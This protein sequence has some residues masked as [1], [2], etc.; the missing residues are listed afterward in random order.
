MH[1]VLLDGAIFKQSK[2]S[3][4]MIGFLEDP[5]K[6]LFF[7]KIYPRRAEISSSSLLNPKNLMNSPS[8]KK[9]VDILAVKAAEITSKINFLK[10]R[11]TDLVIFST[12]TRHNFTVVQATSIKEGFKIKYNS[13]I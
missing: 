11:S 10:K 8:V 12:K 1:E 5:T 9:L 13:Y 3:K 7:I 4:L 6:T 2:W